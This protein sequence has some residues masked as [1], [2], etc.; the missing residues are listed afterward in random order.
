LGQPVNRDDLKKNVAALAGDFGIDPVKF[1][2]RFVGYFPP[3]PSANGHSANGHRQVLPTVSSRHLVLPPPP[4]WEEEPLLPQ[5]RLTLLD[6]PKGVGKGTLAARLAV[7]YLS[8]GDNILWFPAED[9]IEEDV[10]RRL[11]AAGYTQDMP[12]EV[13]F[14]DGSLSIPL[15]QHTALLEATIEVEN[16]E[17]F[18][19]DPVRSYLR[20]PDGRREANYLSS[21]D[22]RPGLQYL[23]KLGKRTRTTILAAHH[24]SRSTD[25]KATDLYAGAAAFAE[26]ARHRLSMALIDGE[27]AIT[28]A[29][30]NIIKNDPKWLRSYRL[31]DTPEFCA[32]RFEL[33]GEMDDT[34]FNAWYARVSQPPTLTMVC[35]PVG[36]L[37][38]WLAK[39]FERGDPLPSREEM[40]HRAELSQPQT[41]KAIALLK[42][43]G[44]IKGGRPLTYLGEVG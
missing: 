42:E 28:V 6:G 20:S 24:W 12:G 34:S 7:P 11:L 26:V 21:S 37:S 31:I 40:Q 18:F 43:A 29:E 14:Y 27:G 10:Y 16:I 36:Q 35:D 4:T 15:E 25:K 23:N 9:D 44:V 2:E 17:F 1:A 19:L 22:M 8:R 3:P 33:G 39:T 30:S 41:K 38:A 13:H 32:G 5:H